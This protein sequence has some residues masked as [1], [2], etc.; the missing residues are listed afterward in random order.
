[1]KP[2]DIEKISTSIQSFSSSFL[3]KDRLI[4]RVLGGR[5]AKPR[6]LRRTLTPKMYEFDLVSQAKQDCKHIVLPE[7][8]DPRIIQ[9]AAQ[10]ANRGI[11]HLT[12]LGNK[13][14]ILK[15]AGTLGVSLTS[16]TSSITLL[17]PCKCTGLL[18]KYAEIYY[19]LRRHKGTVPD[20]SAARDE[21]MDNTCFG[22]MMVYCG[23]ADGLVSGARHTTRH[24]IRPA[25]QIIKTTKPAVKVSSV[26]LMCLDVS[27]VA[28]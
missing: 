23:D 10:L 16:Q 13:E 7:G 18:D 19:Q 27:T 28:S 25:L 11:A 2:T 21:V 6:R 20:V 12:L 17:D 22:T 3:H 14:H 5:C 15:A 26:F 8:T 9:A 24:T 4:E 1:M